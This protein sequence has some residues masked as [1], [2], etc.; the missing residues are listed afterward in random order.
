MKALTGKALEAFEKWAENIYDDCGNG[1]FGKRLFYIQSIDDYKFINTEHY[2]HNVGNSM[3]HAL[4]IEWLDSVGIYVELNRAT[5]GLQ[6][7]WWYYTLSDSR[8]IHLNNHVHNIVKVDTR[9]QATEKAI[10]RAVTI[11][12]EKH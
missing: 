9:Q 5:Q 4:I 2:I 11:F 6:F 7:M 3:L 10:E 8:G 12:N 1:Q